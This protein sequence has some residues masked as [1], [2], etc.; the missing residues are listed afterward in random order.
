MR[1]ARHQLDFAFFYFL[2]DRY[3]IRHAD[4]IRVVELHPGAFIAVVEQ[5]FDPGF[6]EFIIN[7]LRG[8]EK[9]LVLDI[10]RS[11]DNMKRSDGS[12]PGDAR[13]VVARLDCGGHCPLDTDA[14][15]AHY[16]R[17]FSAVGEEDSR[18]HAIGVFRSELENV[19]DFDGLEDVEHASAARA[20][21]ACLDRTKARPLSYADVAFDRDAAKMVIVFVGARRHIAAALQRVVGNHKCDLWMRG[22]RHPNRAE[23]ARACAETFANLIS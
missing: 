10:D 18:A 7:A 4:Q 23:R 6:Y 8:S 13:I 16:Y 22:L 21:L 3:P 17:H 12:G 20:G 14:V 2:A 9:L 1:R 11:D 19:T 5:C 15:A